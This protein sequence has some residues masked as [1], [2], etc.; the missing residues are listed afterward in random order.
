M[1]TTAN[2]AIDAVLKRTRDPQGGGITRDQVRGLLED[3]QRLVNADR[4]YVIERQTLTTEPERIFYPIQSE[5][6]GSARVLS[7]A[8]D[9]RELFFQ[10]LERMLAT[11]GF[12]WFRQI[13]P[14][15]LGWSLAGRNLLVLFPGRTTPAT[16]EVRVA[17][18]TGELPN[19]AAE[20]ELQDNEVPLVVDVAAMLVNLKKKD[21]DV[22]RSLA[23][24][25]VGVSAA[26]GR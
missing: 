25:A 3:A 2:I 15:L 9:G 14:K 21:F 6:G 1:A 5:V 18:K 11:Y 26:R 20:L 13:G 22:M 17:K 19:E 7:V 12:G 10:P 24:R 4:G 23:S 16:I 8:E